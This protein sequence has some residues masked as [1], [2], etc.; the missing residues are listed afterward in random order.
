MSGNQVVRI[1]RAPDGL[2]AP[3]DFEL[4]TEAVAEPGDG[5]VLFRARYM[6]V[7]PAMRRY[8]PAPA[9]APHPL[10]GTAAVGDVVVA[11]PPPP[12]S[13]YTGGFVG[14]VLASR[15]PAWR[16]G[17]LVQ[18]GSRWQTHHIVPGDSLVAVPEGGELLHELGVLGQPGFV[19]WWGV[20]RVAAVKPGETFVVSAAGGAI[21]MVAG[22]LARAAGAR[23]VGIA[24]GEKARYVTE[25]LGFDAC[26]DRHDAPVADALDRL[27]PDGID[28]YFDNVGAD[29]ARACFDRLRDFGRYVVCGM[30]G[31]YNAREAE[32]G[33]PLRPVLRKRLRIEGYVIYDHYDE[34]PAFRSEVSAL[35]A[36]G[37]LRYRYDVRP[38]LA[39]APDALARLLQGRNEGKVV[40]DLGAD[41]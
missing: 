14:E 7:D 22:Q 15:H 25:V 37:D 2:P 20:R 23:V 12:T 29:T 8:L 1:R 41:A 10:G 16:A 27:C 32:T 39:S 17:D 38:G 3:D 5:E 9:G 30:A 40:V 21:G 13:G 35:L 6:S 33:P 4:V 28:V 24:S 19:A 34:F 18:G 31:E 11:G 36:A 26:V